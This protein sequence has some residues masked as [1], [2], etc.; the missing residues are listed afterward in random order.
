MQRTLLPFL[1]VL[2]FIGF[3]ACEQGAKEQE[4]TSP[5]I[6]TILEEQFDLRNDS[7]I[8]SSGTI[9]NFDQA[10]NSIDVYWLNETRDTV[11]RFY[12]KY[13]NNQQLIGAEYYEEGDS[14]PNLDTVYFNTAGQKV[15]AS[16]NAEGIVTWKSTITEDEA[17]NE[18][19]RR[20]E[21]GKGEPRGLDSAYFDTKNRLV[22]GFYQNAAGKKYSI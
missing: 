21:N 11:L 19:L 2:C 15:E 20:Y 5:Q 10:G 6:S 8:F 13:D 3:Q 22:K 1:F 17:G 18:V 7:V 9:E 4:V 12:R 14:L 16:L